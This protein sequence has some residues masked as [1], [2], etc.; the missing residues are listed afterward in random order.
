[1]GGHYRQR[2]F[3]CQLSNG[4]YAFGGGTAPVL[5]ALNYPVPGQT[6]AIARI[7]QYRRA[8]LVLVPRQDSTGGE[9]LAVSQWPEMKGFPYPKQGWF[10]Y[11]RFEQRYIGS[12]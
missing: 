6:A 12:A 10:G 9:A 4:T 2:L 1:M 7:E 11:F 3:A 8:W 5:D